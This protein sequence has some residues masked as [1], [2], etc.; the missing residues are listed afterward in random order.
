MVKLWFTYAAR[1]LKITAHSLA[2]GP[3]YKNISAFH[4]QQCAEKAIKGLLS[5]HRIRFTKTHDLEKLSEDAVQVDAKIA[6][7]V[8][9][10]KILSE[11]AVF[12]RYPDAEK[13]ALTLAQARSAVSRARLIYDRC[14]ASVFEKVS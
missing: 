12:Y 6:K 3:E 4:S 11:Y 8:L 13:K 1:D 9:K 2:F 10:N 5:H 7:L 14:Y